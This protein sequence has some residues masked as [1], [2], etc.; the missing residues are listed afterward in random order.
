MSADLPEIRSRILVNRNHATTGDAVTA[1][2]L[3]GNVHDDRGAGEEPMPCVL[4]ASGLHFKLYSQHGWEVSWKLLAP[5]CPPEP[6]NGTSGQ[7]AATANTVWI[8]SM[9]GWHDAFADESA[10]A[11]DPLCWSQLYARHPDVTPLVAAPDLDE[12]IAIAAAGARWHCDTYHDCAHFNE[13]S[14]DLCVKRRD[15]LTRYGRS[16]TP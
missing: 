15:L 6:R 14:A 7:A 12:L 16:V 10:P 13:C 11:T 4:S 1:E 2:V 5:P 3:V 9:N 8:R